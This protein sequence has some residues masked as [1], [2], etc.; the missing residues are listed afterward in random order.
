MP[1]LY[2]FRNKSS[3]DDTVYSI[4]ER[5]IAILPKKIFAAYPILLIISK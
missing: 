4:L 3:S 5:W 2:D 1:L